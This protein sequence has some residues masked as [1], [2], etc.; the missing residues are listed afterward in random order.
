MSYE[1]PKKAEIELFDSYYKSD[2][3]KNGR[4][5]K[6]F[7]VE[8][9]ER[10]FAVN[11]EAQKGLGFFPMMFEEQNAYASIGYALHS[12]T[13]Y[14]FSE[15]PI[16]YKTRAKGEAEKQDKNG[17]VDFWCAEKNFKFEA[18]IES[19]KLWLNIGK[20]ARWQ[21]DSGCETRI[22]EAISQI[23]RLKSAGVDK[24]TS[25]YTE[26]A[27]FKVALFQ[28]PIVYSYKF[29]PEGSDLES[30]PKHLENLLNDSVQKHFKDNVGLLLN[31]LD[32][33]PFGG[34][35]IEGECNPFN[36]LAVVVT[37]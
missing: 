6:S 3:F 9:C 2:S 32:M 34:E 16:K 33:R 4:M 1:L 12:L 31:V 13:P 19:K 22:N 15:N 30:A 8:F 29:K 28:I 26:G 20:N 17:R 10:A 7:F 11:L 23:K 27:V 14:V 18:Y 25:K 35:E 24:V 37:Q 5:F 21:L 36:V